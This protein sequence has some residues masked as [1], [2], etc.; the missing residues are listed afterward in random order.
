MLQPQLQKV[1]GISEEEMKLI[2]AA[3]KEAEAS[4]KK[5]ETTSKVKKGNSTDRF[6]P[7]PATQ[8][9]MGLMWQMWPQQ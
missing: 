4:R 3:K 8:G 9:S 5:Q 2:K 1:E 6:R 7:Y